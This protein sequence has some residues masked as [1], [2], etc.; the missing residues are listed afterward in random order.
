M[1]ASAARFPSRFNLQISS[2]ISIAYQLS[3]EN[4]LVI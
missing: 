4:C 1:V 2:K 3:S